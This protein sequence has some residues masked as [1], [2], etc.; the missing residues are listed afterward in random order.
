MM[1]VLDR[2]KK[3]VSKGDQ[4]L[5]DLCR[6]ELHEKHDVDSVSYGDVGL[7]VCYE[8]GTK[9]EVSGIKITTSHK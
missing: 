6:K 7:I 5:I 2:L 3:A 1:N 9:P 8:P 4:E